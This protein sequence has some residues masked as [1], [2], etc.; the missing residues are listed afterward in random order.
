M[1]RKLNIALI[2]LILFCLFL[3]YEILLASNTFD[4]DRFITVSKGESFSQVVDSLDQAGVV[5]NRTLFI[6][7]GKLLRLTTRM[8]IG[9]YRFR[10]GASNKEILEDLRHGKNI[11]LITITVREGLKASRIARIYGRNLGIDSTR[12][13]QLVNDSSLAHRFGVKENSLEGYLMPNTYKFYWQ[14]DEE[15]IIAE[16]V[17]QFWLVFSDTL[18]VRMESRHISLNELLALASI[19]E[20]ETNVDSERAIVAGV[21][22]NRLQKRMR[23]EA[24]PTIQYILEDGPRRLHYSDLQRESPYNTYRNYGLP[25]GPVNNPG[26]SSIIAAL[27]PKR[28]RYLYFVANGQGGHTF[29]KT[30][31]EHKRAIQRFRRIREEQQA[32]KEAG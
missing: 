23:L 13:M 9:K 17:K 30:F 7:A 5:R 2:A 6:L 25:P 20:A 26:Q 21:Y 14:S 32:I 8:Q 3:L 27:Y 15:E 29:S 1:I 24:D 19:I 31:V 18:K 28:H 16:M 10:S 4:G 12:F 22:Y 11:E